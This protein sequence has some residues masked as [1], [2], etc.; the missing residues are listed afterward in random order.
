MPSGRL[1][2][3]GVG[4]VRPGFATTA[5]ETVQLVHGGIAGDGHMG[6]TR[7][8]DSRVPWHPRG[9]QIANTRQLSL[10]G[11]EELDETAAILGLA[12]LPAEPVG[13]NLV[14]EGLH[15]LSALP[16]ATRLLFT[17]GAALF[18]TEENHPCSQAAGALAAATGVP[19][20]RSAYAKAAIG[21]RGLVAI[22]EREG[23][24]ALGAE[25]RAILPSARRLP[26]PVPMEL[27]AIA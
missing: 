10:L 8:A 19:S 14:I 26:C 13:G 23:V 12:S 11:A 2:F 16:P 18:V 9:A 25:I 17:G 15:P 21:R 1:V 3:I 20:V 7:A 5:R 6:P 24:I 27:R 4:D 22:V